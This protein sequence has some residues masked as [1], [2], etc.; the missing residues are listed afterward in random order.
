MRDLRGKMA[1]LRDNVESCVRARGQIGMI[2]LSAVDKANAVS[3]AAAKPD[4]QYCSEQWLASHKQHLGQR[5]DVNII[6]EDLKSGI[7][8]IDRN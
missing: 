3:D 5:L 8:V 1:D 6:L 7:Q 4:A 2:F